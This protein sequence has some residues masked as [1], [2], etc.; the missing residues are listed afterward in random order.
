[1]QNNQ[2]LNAIAI[3]TNFKAFPH[4]L[5]QQIQVDENIKGRVLKEQFQTSD[6]FRDDKNALSAVLLVSDKA[7]S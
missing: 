2:W 3:E 1:M 5:R 6:R 4:G 7:M